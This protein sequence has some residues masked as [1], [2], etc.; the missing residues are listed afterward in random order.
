MRRPFRVNPRQ[1]ENAAAAARN[2]P[3]NAARGRG[4]SPAANSRSARTVISAARKTLCTIR[5]RTSHSVCFF[6]KLIPPAALY[7]LF[8][9][10]TRIPRRDRRGGF[11]AVFYGKREK[12]HAVLRA[13]LV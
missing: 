10:S 2:S 12:L 5:Q 11:L 13:H 9:R 7:P 6:S 3:Q 1:S 4:F 8:A